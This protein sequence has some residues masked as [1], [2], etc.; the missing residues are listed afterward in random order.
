T[1]AAAL[2]SACADETQ[3]PTT[4][5][6]AACT[7]DAGTEPD[8]PIS[9]KAGTGHTCT[10]FRS[11]HIRCWGSNADGALGDGVSVLNKSR[12]NEVR[13][14]SNATEIA[15]GADSSCGRLCDGTVMCWGN[16]LFGQLGRSTIGGPD[17]AIVEDFGRVAHIFAGGMTTCTL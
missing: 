13:D 7:V 16:N 3:P 1:V 11:G 17:A 8:A 4:P 14:V 10:L 9:I 12:P 15:L 2:G 5:P 6:V